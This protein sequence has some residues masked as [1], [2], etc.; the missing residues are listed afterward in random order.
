ML[1]R[2]FLGGLSCTLYGALSKKGGRLFTASAFLAASVPIAMAEI[3]NTDYGW[4]GAALVFLFFLADG[5]RT[6]AVAGLILFDAAKCASR[7]IGLPFDFNGFL[8]DAQHFGL[9]ALPFILTASG[10]KGVGYK[11]S[12]FA[13]YYFYIFYPLHMALLALLRRIL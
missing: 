2:S 3:I 9:L 6:G 11:R 5:S 7:H 12:F 4:Y 8:N 1:F 13:R 10:K